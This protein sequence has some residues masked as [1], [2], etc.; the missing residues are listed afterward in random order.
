MA[1]PKRYSDEEI[2]ECRRAS[3]LAYESKPGVQAA[4]AAKRKARRLLPELKQYIKQKHIQ[5]TYDLLPDQWQ[6][7]FVAQGEICAICKSARPN[8]KSN[9]WHTDHCHSTGKV[10]G[11]LCNLCNVALGMFKD[12]MTLMQVA[13]D[14]LSKHKE[15][16]V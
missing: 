14:Y 2:L 8:N 7:L 10:R 4:I 13:I 1:R 3:R 16:Y 5:Y 9:T 6:A 11:I 15:T 12:D